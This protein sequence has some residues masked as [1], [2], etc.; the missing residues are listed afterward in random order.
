MIQTR[1]PR[2]LRS[3]E[4]K[5]IGTFTLRQL[6]SII[7]II[8]ADFVFYNLIIKHMHLSQDIIFWVYFLM[9]TIPVAFGWWKPMGMR[10]ENY[11]KYVFCN[12][13]L[14]PANKAHRKSQFTQIHVEYTPKEIRKSNKRMK[15]AIKSGE[16]QWIDYECKR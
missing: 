10:M 1:V 2:D 3:Y 11:L 6:V 7:F 13:F 16:I 9:D 4:T 8:V 15:Q 14:S 5:V 12:L